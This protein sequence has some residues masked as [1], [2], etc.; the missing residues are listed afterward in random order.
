ML[1]EAAILGRVLGIAAVVPTAGQPAPPR[2]VV[3]DPSVD[4]FGTEIDAAI[5]ADD[6]RF[7]RRGSVALVMM[8]ATDETWMA[9]ENVCQLDH[10]K[11]LD[12]KHSGAGRGFRVCPLRRIG[13]SGPRRQTLDHALEAH[14]PQ[15]F[16]DWPFRGPSSISEWLKGVRASGLGFSA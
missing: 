16:T 12:E 7:V 1:A 5:L 14:R 13:T 4:E 3:S 10:V 6:D 15:S 9:C 8:A 11:W 2:W